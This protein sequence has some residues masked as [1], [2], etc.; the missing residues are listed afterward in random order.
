[1]AA[2]NEAQVQLL[3]LQALL[4]EANYNLEVATSLRDSTVDALADADEAL[5]VAT[6]D[7]ETTDSAFDDAGTNK[8]AEED[9]L[10]DI[11]TA[12]DNA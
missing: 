2:D 5:R 6:E 9:E 12:R 8:G 3:N 11:E 10:G 1:M 7:K 4:D